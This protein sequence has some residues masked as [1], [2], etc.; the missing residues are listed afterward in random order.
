MKAYKGC[1]PASATGY[2]GAASATGVRGVASAAGTRGMA[3][4]TGDYGVASATGDQ[5]VASATGSHS[6]A[7]A[8]G[9]QSRAKGALCCGLTIAERD[10]GGALLDRMGDDSMTSPTTTAHHMEDI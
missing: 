7:L 6:I 10:A 5:G 4:A 8:A 1:A 2:R 9:Y 3:S